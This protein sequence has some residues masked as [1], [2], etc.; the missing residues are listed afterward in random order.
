MEATAS[1]IAPAQAQAINGLFRRYPDYR[2]NTQ[3][4]T[5]L[6]AELYKALLPIVGAGKMVAAANALLRLERV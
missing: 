4:E 3:Q 2:W 6:R 5:A 1:G